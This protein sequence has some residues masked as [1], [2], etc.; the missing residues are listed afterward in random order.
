MIFQHILAIRGKAMKTL[1]T[2]AL[3][4]GTL[5]FAQAAGAVVLAPVDPVVIDTTYASLTGSP[6]T[7]ARIDFVNHLNTAVDVYWI[8]YSGNRVFYNTLA[9]DSSYIQGTFITHPWLIALAGS[10]DTTAQGTGTLI[11]AFASAVTITPFGSQNFDIAN[12]GVPEPATW[13]MLIAGMGLIG[14][15]MRRRRS[16]VSSAA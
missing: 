11:T 7:A 2:A 6:S 16:A 13:S 10:G 15:A 14:G 3:A 1:M 4:V 9:A 8:D 5:S 12:I